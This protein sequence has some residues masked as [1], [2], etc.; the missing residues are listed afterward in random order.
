MMRS[1]C[2]RLAPV[3]LRDRKACDA[4]RSDS[5]LP[6]QLTIRLFAVYRSLLQS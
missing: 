2:Y 6:M 5:L 4:P 1:Q 3:A